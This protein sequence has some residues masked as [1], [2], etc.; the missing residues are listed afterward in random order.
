MH[1]IIFQTMTCHIACSGTLSKQYS[2][3]T[4]QQPRPNSKYFMAFEYSVGN[5][6]VNRAYIHTPVT[7]MT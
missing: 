7:N 2:M 6:V 1:C 5:F 3:S 4:A